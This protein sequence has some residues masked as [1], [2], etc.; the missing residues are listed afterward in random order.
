M[1]KA[2]QPWSIVETGGVWMDAKGERWEGSSGTA[3][4]PHPH[5]HP[6]PTDH[7]FVPTAF[8]S[9]V[10]RA[11]APLGVRAPRATTMRPEGSRMNLGCRRG[12]CARRRSLS[13]CRPCTTSFDAVDLASMPRYRRR[14]WNSRRFARNA[15]SC[16]SVIDGQSFSQQG[17]LRWFAGGLVVPNRP[18]T[19]S[20]MSLPSR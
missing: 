5:P 13:R 18:W 15:S 2:C 6:A 4:A 16:S 1:R 12:S 17:G 20:H 14:F 9:E 8:A 7:L 3:G 19:R 11:S 10:G